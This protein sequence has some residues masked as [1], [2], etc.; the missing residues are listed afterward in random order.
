MA[1]DKIITTW[2]LNGTITDTHLDGEEPLNPRQ[3]AE[4]L[5]KDLSAGIKVTLIKLSKIDETTVD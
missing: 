2:Q 4:E 1:T 5:S 3:I